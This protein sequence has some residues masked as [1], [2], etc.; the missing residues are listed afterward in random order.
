VRDTEI[1]E[2]RFSSPWRLSFLLRAAMVKKFTAFTF[3]YFPTTP[4]SFHHGDVGDLLN[5]EE[6]KLNFLAEHRYLLLDADLTLHFFKRIFEVQLHIRTLI[7]CR[8]FI[9]NNMVYLIVMYF[10][11]FTKYWRNFSISPLHRTLH[12]LPK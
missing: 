4:L 3:L 6:S 8:F 9:L 5:M 11:N 2:E 1:W 10:K 12:R 7:Y